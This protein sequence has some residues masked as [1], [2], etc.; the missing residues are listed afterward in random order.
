MH[1]AAR[2]LT[3]V[4]AKLL[5]AALPQARD[6]FGCVLQFL[7]AWGERP[8]PARRGPARPLPGGAQAF[9][10]CPAGLAGYA[11]SI[12]LACRRPRASGGKGPAVADAHVFARFL[13]GLPA[14]L[15]AAGLAAGARVRVV[16]KA[17]SGGSSRG[18]PFRGFPPQ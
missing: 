8:V 4:H 18:A 14:L 2:P 12:G 3:L 5:P 13:A 7:V 1:W 10:R 6:P 11:C 9:A 15:A 17:S 16:A